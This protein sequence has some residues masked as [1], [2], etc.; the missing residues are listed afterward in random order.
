MYHVD[1]SLWIKI[2]VSDRLV[3]ERFCTELWANGHWITVWNGISYPLYV[4][5]VWGWLDWWWDFGWRQKCFQ[6]TD[7]HWYSWYPSY[8]PTAFN[9]P[10][11]QASVSDIYSLEGTTQSNNLVMVFYALGTTPLVNT[12]WITLPKVRQVCLADDISGSDSF[13]DLIIW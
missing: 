1:W 5:H 8:L 4:M 12:L 13:D 6:F 2:P 3:W 7:I 11:Q 9:Y 10:S